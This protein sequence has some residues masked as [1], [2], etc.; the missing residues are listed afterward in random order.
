MPSTRVSI[1]VR[2]GTTSRYDRER[3]RAY[4]ER[5]SHGHHGHKHSRFSSGDEL[6]PISRRDLGHQD[7]HRR[8]EQLPNPLPFSKIEFGNALQQLHTTLRDSIRFFREFEESYLL[9]TDPIKPYATPQV[10]EDLWTAKALSSDRN[11]SRISQG[12]SSG[13]D[14][15]RT[16]IDE[17]TRPRSPPPGGKFRDHIQYI[18]D[19]FET[20]L[21]CAPSR[22]HRKQHYR[23]RVSSIGCSDSVASAR[24]DAES[25]ERLTEKVAGQYKVIWKVLCDIYNFQSYVQEFIK[26]SELL[27]GYLD[28]SRNL[29]ELEDQAR[30]RQRQHK[31]E[32][33]QGYGSD[34]DN[35]DSAHEDSNQE[36]GDGWGS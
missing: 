3:L 18:K 16:S 13:S 31:R 26:E 5:H 1:P 36:N 23:E 24:L 29:W 7:R 28:K 32:D 33:R 30:S 10:L 34:H 8:R 35:R 19:D 20:A 11:H 17:Q 12:N 15:G 21:S 2:G 4:D 22:S 9:E 25:T 6:P 14:N 27:A